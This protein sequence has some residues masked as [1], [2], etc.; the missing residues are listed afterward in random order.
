[1]V[2][3]FFVFSISI[4]FMGLADCFHH[5]ILHTSHKLARSRT[6]LFSTL[7]VLSICLS[8]A[9]LILL[10]GLRYDTGYDYFYSYVPSLEAVRNG[11]TSHY[12]PLFNQILAAFAHLPDNQWFFLGTAFFTV[13]VVYLSITLVFNYATV[14]LALFLFSFH[15]LRSFCFVAQYTAM[16]V[17]LLGFVLLIKNRRFSALLLL[18]VSIL[19]HQSAFI[20]I[21][22]YLIYFMPSL[23]V[24][25]ASASLPILVF[26]LKGPI[27]LL[28]QKMSSVTRFSGYLGSDFDVAYTDN[29]LI[30]ANLLFFILFMTLWVIKYRTSSN[31]RIL[32]LFCAAQS[33]ALALSLTQGIVP[34][35]YRFVW[36]YMFF[37]VISIPFILKLFTKRNLYILCSILIILFYTAWMIKFPIANGASQILPYHPIF[38]TTL[39]FY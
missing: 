12:D 6:V 7:R 8:A 17:A 34:V 22:L 13:S 19:L 32:R 33:I 1:M 18:I 27:S 20:L 25:V 23:L 37:Q 16:A 39:S 36:Y 21:P 31:S 35:G 2:L 29:S 30:L 15:Y 9:P 38:N 14:P 24:I 10:S 26:I 4:L 11:G 3:Y 5:A 28:V